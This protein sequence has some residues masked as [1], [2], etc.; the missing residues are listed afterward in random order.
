MINV[1]VICASL[2]T[3]ANSHVELVETAAIWE[4]VPGNA[5]LARR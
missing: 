4:H 3:P 2:T 1:N 5:S